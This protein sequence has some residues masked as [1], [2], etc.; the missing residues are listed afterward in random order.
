[1]YPESYFV[2]AM[3]IIMVMCLIIYIVYAVYMMNED[4]LRYIIGKIV[5]V[6]PLYDNVVKYNIYNN[7]IDFI[8]MLRNITY[9][10]TGDIAAENTKNSNITSIPIDS[11]VMDWMDE[12]QYCDDR[13]GQ[14]DNIYYDE[15]VKPSRSIFTLY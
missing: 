2:C 1:M 3:L 5:Y 8:M 9:C 11:P 10:N 6:M 12:I 4:K 15:T 13:G 14:I 7:I